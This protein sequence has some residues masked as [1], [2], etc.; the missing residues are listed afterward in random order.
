MKKQVFTFKNI[1]NLDSVIQTVLPTLS[2]D[3][4]YYVKMDWHLYW[5]CNV[6]LIGKDLKTSRKFFCSNKNFAETIEKVYHEWQIVTDH[7]NV[8]IE[9]DDGNKYVKHNRYPFELVQFCVNQISEVKIVSNRSNI[10]SNFGFMLDAGDRLIW[11]QVAIDYFDYVIDSALFVDIP[12]DANK[13][14]LYYITFDFVKNQKDYNW[15]VNLKKNLSEKH[16]ATVIDT[17][18]VLRQ[19]KYK[20]YISVIIS[21]IRSAMSGGSNDGKSYIAHLTT[22]D[23]IDAK[24]FASVELNDPNESFCVNDIVHCAKQHI[25][26][27]SKDH[28]AEYYDGMQWVIDRLANALFNDN[29]E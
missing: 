27:K 13:R 19:N 23:E 3:A 4:F 21:T 16:I 10:M 15:H 8:R 29:H 6:E 17:H 24:R 11:I 12:F 22:Q 1:A 26:N 28:T 2:L 25:A 20:K 5:N 7:A 18:N 9:I 14:P